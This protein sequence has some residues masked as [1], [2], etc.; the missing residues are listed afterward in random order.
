[1]KRLSLHQC[2]ILSFIIYIIVVTFNT[3]FIATDEYWDGI[4]RYLPAQ[5]AT[6]NT[7]IRLDDVKSPLQILPMHAAAQLAYKL[8]LETP[9]SQYHFVIIFWGLIGFALSAS[10]AILLFRGKSESLAKV[11]VLMLG[12]HFVAPGLLTRPMFESLAAPWMA[13][14]CAF[15]VL[16][17]EKRH[18][19]N[20]LAGVFCASMSF[21][22]RQQTGFCA[23]V[24]ILLPL[25]HKQ[26]KH[27]FLASFSGLTLFILSGV[28]DIFIR[29]GF[30]Y[31]L[32]ALAEYNFKH[33]AEYANQPWHFFFPLI[34]I[35]TLMPWLI[36]KYPAGFLGDYIKRYRSLY[37]IL[38][39]FLILHSMFANKF[40]RFLISMIPVLI[41]IMVPFVNYFVEN[42]AQRKYRLI[43]MLAVNLVFWFPAS[44]FPAQKNITDLARYMD[45]HPEYRALQSIDLS[46]EWI[47]DAFMKQV[48][49]TVF[50][51]STSQL[52]TQAIPVNCDTLVALNEKAFA[53]NREFLLFHYKFLARFDVNMIESIAYKF[54][55]ENNVRRSPLMIFSCKK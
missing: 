41:F 23:L 45:E 28:P 30:H 53:S 32:R 7:L 26:W 12:F 34:F 33:G 48:N 1:M 24:F 8:G 10:A 6:V 9:F 4:T 22:L 29:G 40:E 52:Q 44:F 31:S 13:L 15:A 2:L 51:L 19:Q 37:I 17:D 20:L 46:I 18:W 36:A 43:S 49:Y 54:N 3:G 11:A 14:A 50:Q 21:T 25:L 42:W 5:K 55:A 39:L 16:Y 35:G 27:F 38:A 47:P